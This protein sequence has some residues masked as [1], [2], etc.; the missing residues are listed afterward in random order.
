MI[1]G[2][3]FK[4][5]AAHFLPDHPT[6]G[7][8][9]GHTWTVDVELEGRLN[10]QGM[11]FDFGQLKEIMDHILRNFDHCNLN[12]FINHPTCEIIATYLGTSLRT[13]LEK[14]PFV[15][16]PL[17]VKVYSVKVKE[18]EGGYAIYRP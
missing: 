11:V 15:S 3:R 14:I 9:H 18:G 16:I 8:V 10:D 4:F 17:D 2:K 6:C 13:R 12:D 5:D 1:I 7:Q